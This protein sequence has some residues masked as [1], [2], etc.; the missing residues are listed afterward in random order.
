MEETLASPEMV[1]INLINN[2]EKISSV[3]PNKIIELK[4]YILKENR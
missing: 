1:K 3:I 2:L 4:G